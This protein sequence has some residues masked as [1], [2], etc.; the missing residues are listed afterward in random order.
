VSI[1]SAP[2]RPLRV[3]FFGTYR[4]GYMRNEILIDGLRRAGAEVLECHAPLWHGIEDRVQAARGGWAS[5]GFLR[6]VVT[7][8]AALLM[9]YRTIGPYD[10]MMV[11][12]PG[13]FDVFLARLLT[14]LRRK[15]LAWDILMSIY[16]VA[17]DRGLHHDS[18]F[19]VRGMRM[20]EALGLRLPDLLV[21]DTAQ[22]VNYYCETHRLKPDRFRLVPMGADDRLFQPQPRPSADGTFR[23]M[24]Y[25]TFIPNHGVGYIVEAARL[26]K[27]EP[28][29]HFEFVG[30]GPDRAAAQSAAAR[31]G[32]RNV[33]FIDWVP[34]ADLAARAARA[35]V[36]LGAFGLVQQ[37]LLTVHNKIYEGLALARPVISGDSAA[38]RATLTH[39]QHV[40]LVDRRQP[41]E[42]AQAITLLRSEPSLRE[43]LAR[44][45]HQLYCERHSPAILGQR[46]LGHLL[47]VVAR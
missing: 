20:V 1:S 4:A 41:N 43:H 30:D 22:Y 9:H 31:D 23:V 36:C 25:G 46:L 7:A 42:L 40:Y 6:R 21:A 5:V 17:V 39:G 11:A 37:S 33:T 29:I 13:Q 16:L 19:T 3:C 35:D 12:Y 38:V 8:Y 27:G 44:Q 34:R 28:D 45:G 10:V 15:P 32:L 2:G 14:S 47:E 24:Y 18:P 26:L